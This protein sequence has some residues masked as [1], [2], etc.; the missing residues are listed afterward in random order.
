MEQR[1]VMLLMTALAVS[2]S[3]QQNESADTLLVAD[4][5][6]QETMPAIF[7]VRKLPTVPSLMR[8]GY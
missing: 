8:S 5:A 2:V 1:F 7:T 3:A 6:E 4:K